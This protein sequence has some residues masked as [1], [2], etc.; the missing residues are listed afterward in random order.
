MQEKQTS[1]DLTKKERPADKNLRELK[2][3]KDAGET[4]WMIKKRKL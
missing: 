4:H 3:K 2:A 1:S